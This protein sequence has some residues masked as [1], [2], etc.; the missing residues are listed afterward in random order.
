MRPIYLLL[1]LF[2]SCKA[3]PVKKKYTGP[4]KPFTVEELTTCKLRYDAEFIVV[5]DCSFYKE[6]EDFEKLF[7]PSPDI[8]FS[9]Y[10]VG[11]ILLDNKVAV[12]SHGQPALHDINLTLK[13]DSS[14]MK[15][16]ELNVL[17]TATRVDT[18]PPDG[19]KKKFFLFKVPK[20]AGI[21]KVIIGNTQ[22]TDANS[23][24]MD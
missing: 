9:R 15:N 14:Y 13:I 2:V 10:A 3:Q 4:C 18:I 19:Y 11:A 6:Q 5:V 12:L 22:K 16:C 24:K 1:L 8:D 17:Y 23:F 20:D 7:L 21:T